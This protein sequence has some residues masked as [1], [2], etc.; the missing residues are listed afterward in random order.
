VF[1]VKAGTELRHR[2]LG[3]RNVARSPEC[4]KKQDDGVFHCEACVVRG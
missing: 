4:K 1:C 2:I 3:E